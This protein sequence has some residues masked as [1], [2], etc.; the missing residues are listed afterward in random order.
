[1]LFIF[2][3]EL[4]VVTVIFL[5]SIDA[6]A[7]RLTMEVNIGLPKLELSEEQLATDPDRVPRTDVNNNRQ[8]HTEHAPGCQPLMYIS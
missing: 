5:A 2:I 7:F 3:P 4:H 8:L 1:M 6:Y